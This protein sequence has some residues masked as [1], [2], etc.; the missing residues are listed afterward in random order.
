MTEKKKR[1]LIEKSALT[2]STITGILG[3]ITGMPAVQVIAYFPAI[4]EKVILEQCDKKE[5]IERSLHSDLKSAINGTCIEVQNKIESI[6][7]ELSK[8]FNTTSMSIVKDTQFIFS[9]ESMEE[10]IRGTLKKEKK[11]ECPEITE[12]DM[13]MIIELFLEKFVVQLLQYPKLVDFLTVNAVFGLEKR[14]SDLEEAVW[15]QQVLKDGVSTVLPENIC[16]DVA[17]YKMKYEEVLFLHRNMPKEKQ[18]SL[19]D[20]FVMPLVTLCNNNWPNIFPYSEKK[21]IRVIH[22][23]LCYNSENDNS[24]DFMFVEGQAAMGKSS[25]VS[26]LA[27]QYCCQPEKA[28][29]YFNGKRLIVVRLRDL[30][31]RHDFLD[32]QSPLTDLTAYL[33]E[34]EISLK[35]KKE[36]EKKIYKDTVLVLDGFDE[37]CMVESIYGEGKNTYFYNMYREFLKLNCACKIIVTTRPNYLSVDG[38]DFPKVHIEIKG[39]SI[40]KRNVWMTKYQEKEYISP[41]VKLELLKNHDI[42]LECLLESPMMLYMIIAKKIEVG[43]SLNMWDLYHKIF[44]EEIYERNYDEE[45]SH[46]LWV[47]KKYLY[48]LTAEIANAVCIEKRFFITVEKLLERT[49]IKNLVKKITGLNEMSGCEKIQDILEDC[50][51]VASYFKISKKQDENGLNKNAVE[52]YHNN[53]RDYFYCEYIWINLQRIYKEVIDIK[54]GI[55]EKFISEYQ[56]MFQYSDFLDADVING[57]IS[58][59]IQFFRDKVYYYKEKNIEENF[60]K[61]ELDKRYFKYFFGQ[62]LQT[63]FLYNYEYSAN[64]NI[65]NLI[66]NIYS[67]VLYIYRAIYLPYL[68]NNEKIELSEKENI[69][70][71]NRCN[72]LKILFLVAPIRQQTYLKFDGMTF[73]NVECQKYDFSYSSFEGCTM[74]RAIFRGCNLNCANLSHANLSYANLEYTNLTNA[75]LR[76]TD[77]GR[78]NLR[79]A[80]LRNVKMDRD[81]IFDE[82]I[83]EGTKISESLLIYIGERKDGEVIV[84]TEN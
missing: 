72:I 25:L 83:F 23:F 16:G 6:S 80:D 67:A 1:D 30:L 47:Y 10:W 43:S 26:W 66:A 81:T 41:E 52:F 57:D 9:F 45:G 39:F 75:D 5:N 2:A 3:V 56:S 44:A 17:E 78:A 70:N 51:G 32:V 24:V 74:A 35:K 63:G 61:Q 49:E 40:N 7:T 64:E 21:A 77:L 68:K 42:M 58:I 28:R 12:K 29:I 71:I 46:S 69:E 33:Y 8:F 55:V 4:V 50:F 73:E 82:T 15:K 13:E 54:S 31:Q 59:P 11:W 19:K 14:V 27:W 37:L 84:C 48:E 22:D 62:M 20:I 36:I 60:L 38:L 76:G 34:S 18:I 79:N 53:I 65:L